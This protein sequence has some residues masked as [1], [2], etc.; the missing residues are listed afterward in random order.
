MAA[1]PRADQAL[2]GSSHTRAGPG[3]GGAGEEGVVEAPGM[4]GKAPGGSVAV[5]TLCQVPPAG[6]VEWPWT[7]PLVLLLLQRP[8]A[9]AGPS[10]S[11]GESAPLFPALGEPLAPTCKLAAAPACS[12]DLCFLRPRVPPCLTLTLGL[13]ARGPL[14]IDPG[15][16]WQSTQCP[17]PHPQRPRAQVGTW[18]HPFP[19]GRMPRGHS[20]RALFAWAQGRQTFSHC[21]KEQRFPKPPQ[22][23]FWD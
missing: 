21:K 3:P 23:V 2:G 19:E 22:L 16:S 1:E 6:A 13:R 20:V 18:P 17:L 10:G 8:R 9:V 12:S 11:R 7:S 5:P 15:S 4:L 14:W